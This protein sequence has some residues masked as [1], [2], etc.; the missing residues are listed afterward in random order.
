M[1]D[2]LGLDSKVVDVVDNNCINREVCLYR[3]THVFIE[4]L[5]VVPS[6]IEQLAK[7]HPDVKW[8]IR[9]HSNTPFI[10]NEGVAIDWILGYLAIDSPNV[11]IAPNSKNFLGDLISIG[12]SK[13]KVNYLPNYY[14]F[15]KHS[16]K[17]NNLKDSVHIG[18]FG[19][20]R[21]LKNQLIQAI[22][23]INFAN[24]I[25]KDLYFHINSSRVEQ[26][27]NNVLKNLRALFENGRHKLVE[28]NWLK[29]DDFLVL[30]GNM[31]INMQVSLTETFNITVADSVNE[32]VPVV[33]SKEVDWID[34]R[35]HADPTSSIDIF[36]RLLL[37]WRNK[38]KKIA[39]KN[40]YDLNSYNL[41]S[42]H[43]W[44]SFLLS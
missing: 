30:V 13:S 5:W 1:L 10:A 22:A 34:S 8:I 3:P 37:I 24:T 18:C 2:R 19:A 11:I 39:K 21:P 28:H 40:W 6:K 44:L 27:G 20:I 4:A 12:A 15:R 16:N 7:L 33:V 25:N 41:L 31:D 17:L 38:D 9:I 43:H 35:F 29:H 26:S 14:E 23:A 42:V 36:G 32:L